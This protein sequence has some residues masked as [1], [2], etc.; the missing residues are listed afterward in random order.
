M[1][2]RRQ[3][4]LQELQKQSFYVAHDGRLLRELSLEELETERVRLPEIME[5]KA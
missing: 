2:L 3:V 1:E 4:L 5:A